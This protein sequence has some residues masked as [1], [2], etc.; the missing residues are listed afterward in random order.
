MVTADRTQSEVAEPKAV[1]M[2]DKV[3]KLKQQMRGPKE[4]E[5]RLRDAPHG[6]VQ[7]SDP[8]ARSMATSGRGTGSV[9]YNVQTA[10]DDKRHLIV[11]QEA[12]LMRTA[13]SHS[14]DPNLPPD[15]AKA[16]RRSGRA[17]SGSASTRQP[18][19]SKG[20]RPQT[21]IRH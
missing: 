14:L 13:F 1:R 19:V 9:G 21:A 16:A 17:L 4:M 8:D 6:Q 7:L 12:R 3:E 11:A 15:C 5:Q 18:L 20:I 2:E 10:V